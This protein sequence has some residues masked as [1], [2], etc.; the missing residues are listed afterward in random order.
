MEA[1]KTHIKGFKCVDAPAQDGLAKF[2]LL[3]DGTLV[4]HVHDPHVADSSHDFPSIIEQYGKVFAACQKV[5][6]KVLGE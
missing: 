3:A 6:A 2:D 4:F 5:V 1:L